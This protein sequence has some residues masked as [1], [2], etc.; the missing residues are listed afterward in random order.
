MKSLIFA[1]MCSAPM[2]ATCTIVTTGYPLTGFLNLPTL[3]T[4]AQ[5]SSYSTTLTTSGCASPITWTSLLY[6]STASVVL[7]NSFTLGSSTGVLASSY[8]YEE[9]AFPIVFTATDANSAVANATLYL[10]IT[11]NDTYGNCQLFPANS[12]FY[13][14]IN[15]LPASSSAV[16]PSPS[17]V[18]HPNFGYDITSSSGLPFFMVPSNQ[19]NLVLDIQNGFGTLPSGNHSWPYVQ[20]PSYEGAIGNSGMDHHS[21]WL[22]TNTTSTSPPAC[23]GLFGPEYYEVYT[24]GQIP[25]YSS[26]SPNWTWYDGANW[27]TASNT[28]SW[29]NGITNA[30]G[31]P[32]TNLL[33]KWQDVVNGVNHPL[34]ITFGASAAC[35]IWPATANASHDSG[36]LCMGQMFRLKASTNINTY[37]PA[38]T[39]PQGHALLLGLQTYGAYVIDN[40]S[41]G[42]ISGTPNAN[43]NDPDLACVKSYHESDLEAVNQLVLEVSNVS[44]ATQPIITTTSLPPATA[45][46][47][48][49]ALLGATGGT[50]I[51][52]F[53]IATGSLPP[54]LSINSSTGAITGTPTMG[55]SYPFGVQITDGINS[56]ISSFSINVCGGSQQSYSTQLLGTGGTY[57]DYSWSLASGSLPAGLSLSTNGIISGT[58]T[59]TAP[60]PYS[61]QIG[62]SGGFGGYTFTQTSGSLPPGFSMNSSGLIAG[63]ITNTNAAIYPFSVQVSDGTNT[64]SANLSILCCGNQFTVSLTDGSNTTE[65]TLVLPVCQSNSSQSVV[66]PISLLGIL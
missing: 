27:N 23:S 26:M 35:N 41:N 42:F 15:G 28:A 21:F 38:N 45:S 29:N 66:P 5:Y 61:Y 50:G 59:P 60:Q 20:Y 31:I 4:G 12:I 24:A 46:V 51:Y 8:I 43:F 2:F 22:Q 65:S 17:S 55:G 49:S 6:N 10:P 37:C 62:A 44:F 34:A 63:T 39:N 13:Q 14:P 11:S 47:T 53:S 52:T 40:G 16:V 54:G 57:A 1:V 9:G 33:F 19:A 48:Y 32:Y 36:T 25:T 64:S 30:A 18:L 3:P 58:P 56:T 7:P